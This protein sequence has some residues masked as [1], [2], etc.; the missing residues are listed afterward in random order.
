ML[1]V[2][3]HLS[4]DDHLPLVA[5]KPIYS[6]DVR[7]QPSLLDYLRHV[8]IFSLTPACSIWRCRAW[9]PRSRLL[10]LLCLSWLVRIC[11]KLKILVF[12]INI[13]WLQWLTV[14]LLLELAALLDGDTILGLRGQTLM[15]HIH[16]PS[17]LNLLIVLQR[18]I[19]F[20]SQYLWDFYRCIS[21]ILHPQWT[22]IP[23]IHRWQF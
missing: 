4:I 18:I 21:L 22:D 5:A 16:I 23:W 19:Y 13:V 8:W 1:L 15:D 9:T 6:P 20:T 11:V 14:F 10:D 2:I 12:I 7:D 3:K 17:Q